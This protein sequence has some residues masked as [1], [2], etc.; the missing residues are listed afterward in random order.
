VKAILGLG[1]VASRDGRFLEQTRL[2]LAYIERRV[3]RN[4]N[5]ESRLHEI[6]DSLVYSLPF[7]MKKVISTELVDISVARQPD[8]VRARVENSHGILKDCFQQSLVQLA[9]V[10]DPLVQG[11]DIFED[12]TAKFEQSVELREQLARLVH[13]VREFQAKRDDAAAADMKEAISRFYDTDMKYL[14]YRDWSGFELFYIEILKCGHLA[15]LQQIGHRFETFLV[16]L[17]REVQKRS[18][19]QA[20]PL[21]PDL[22]G[23]ET[24][25]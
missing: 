23:V 24:A 20:A 21:D 13:V 19:L 4:V 15:G 6:Y 2:L 14:M 17:F 12:F 1:Y 22:A 18:I 10:F 3:L 7:E 11:R 25:P 8:I 16:T 5:A 9:Q